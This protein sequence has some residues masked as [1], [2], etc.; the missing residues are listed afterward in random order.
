M[1]VGTFGKRIVS[2]LKKYRYV[3]IVLAIGILLLLWPSG[4]SDETSDIVSSPKMT[5]EKIEVETKLA[6]ILSQVQGAGKVQVML[7]EREGEQT[8]FQS[9][10]DQKTDSD[11]SS[12]KTE[13]V[14]ISDSQRTEMG[15]I[16]QI[17]PPKFQGA[18]VVCQGADSPVVRLLIVEAVS[19]VTG[20]GSDCIS[21]LKMK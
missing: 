11:S 13:T 21:V 7:T 15:L 16:K 17:N 14:V 20:L 18:I 8:I 5:S 19:K 1:E 9:D 2:C 12:F 10:Q 3:L 4:N 6:E